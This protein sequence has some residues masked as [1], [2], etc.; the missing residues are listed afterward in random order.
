[1]G[2]IFDRDEKLIRPNRRK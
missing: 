2:R 1:M